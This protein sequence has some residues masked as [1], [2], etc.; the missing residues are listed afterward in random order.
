MDKLLLIPFAA[1]FLAIQFLV[2]TV[3]CF[4]GFQTFFILAIFNEPDTIYT[5]RVIEFRIQFFN[6]LIILEIPR[7]RNRLFDLILT[8]F[9]ILLFGF[10][11]ELF[12]F[13]SHFQ[14][15]VSYQ[16][17][18]IHHVFT[19]GVIDDLLLP[20]QLKVPDHTR[21]IYFPVERVSVYFILFIKIDHIWSQI[22]VGTVVFVLHDLFVTQFLIL[23]DHFILVPTEP[24]LGF[25]PARWVQ[26]QIRIGFI[27]LMYQIILIIEFIFDDVLII[28]ELIQ[29]YWGW[30]VICRSTQLYVMVVLNIRLGFHLWYSDGWININIFS[31]KQQIMNLLIV[32]ID[33]LNIFNVSKIVQNSLIIINIQNHL[34]LVIQ[35]LIF[36]YPNLTNTPS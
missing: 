22:F 11:L 16:V 34:H 36:H 30:F 27:E 5:N 24:E 20:D 12:E 4:N 29:S 13:P 35:T 8:F 17:A 3:L 19:A 9:H 7:E 28:Y 23:L 10:L 32:L 31:L 2:D 21:I 25:L 18:Y 33:I 15:I 14:S 26:M 1:K 6:F